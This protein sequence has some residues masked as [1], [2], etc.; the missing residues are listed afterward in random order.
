MILLAQ[1]WWESRKLP[2]IFICAGSFRPVHRCPDSALT[3]VR[4]CTLRRPESVC[5]VPNEN[6]SAHTAKSLF[7]DNL[8]CACTAN[9]PKKRRSILVTRVRGWWGKES[10]FSRSTASL[11]SIYHDLCSSSQYSS[12][13]IDWTGLPPCGSLGII[14]KRICVVNSRGGSVWRRDWYSSEISV[15][16]WP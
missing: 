4:P 12:T 10:G 9:V 11:L 6:P 13:S 16:L 5:L 3:H 14:R 7:H 2:G 15:C 8:T 1:S